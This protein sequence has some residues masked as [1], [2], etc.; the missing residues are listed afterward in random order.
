MSQLDKLS[1]SAICHRCLHI[2]MCHPRM[3]Q[4]VSKAARLIEYGHVCIGP[5]N[6]S[7]SASLVTRNMED[8]VT[9]VNT[10]KIKCKILKYSDKLYD[11]DLL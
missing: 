11:F 7:D 3:A 8:F 9:W 1:I 2:V 4:H 10:S 5:D 6:V